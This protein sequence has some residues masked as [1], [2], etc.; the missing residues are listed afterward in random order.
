MPFLISGVSMVIAGLKDLNSGSGDESIGLLLAGV[1]FTG[2][3]V[4]PFYALFVKSN[5]YFASLPLR[6]QY[7][8]QPWMWREDWAQGIVRDKSRAAM[9]GR[10]MAAVLAS[11]GLLVVGSELR[12]KFDYYASAYPAPAWAVAGLAV[13]IPVA[14]LLRA[15]YTT[16]QYRKFGSSTLVLSKNPCAVGSRVSGRVES[17]LGETPQNGATLRLECI[18]TKRQSRGKSSSTK[19]T[20]VWFADQTLDSFRL[21]Q[22]PAGV[23]VPVE[24]AIPSDAQATGKAGGGISYSWK[25]EVSAKLPGVDYRCEFELP[26]FLLDRDGMLL[27]RGSPD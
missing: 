9:I 13:L 25:L 5:S 2:V 1:A 14:L 26:V 15:I 18:R 21:R 12:E 6:K 8:G 10:W 27:E 23:Y 17:S 7:P 3:A 20:T 4:L 19:R 16:L 11:V 24:F 22:G